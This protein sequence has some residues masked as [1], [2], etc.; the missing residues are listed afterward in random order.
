MKVIFLDIDGVL[1]TGDFIY[2]LGED[3][4][5]RKVLRAN[6]HNYAKMLDLRACGLLNRI[7][8][9]T[10]AKIVVSSTW[11][12]LH[13]WDNLLWMLTERAGVTGD[14]I[15]KT[16]TGGR[17]R[18]HEIEMWL[19][20]HPGVVRFIILDDDSDIA[21]F[22]RH[23]IKTKFRDPYGGLQPGHVTRAIELLGLKQESS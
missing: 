4:E 22:E 21:P 15:D 6:I 16:P 3:P 9:V 20:K 1:N 12:I 14:I 5:E 18:G 19:D 10:G 2:A 17:D 11:R 8:D 23:W 13:S 7:T